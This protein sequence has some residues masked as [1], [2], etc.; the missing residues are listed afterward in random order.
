MIE[1]KKHY[2]IGG[3][4]GAALDLKLGQGV[5]V[6]PDEGIFSRSPAAAFQMRLRSIVMRPVLAGVLSIALVMTLLFG[7]LPAI[8]AALK[9]IGYEQVLAGIW[10]T[11]IQEFV[12]CFVYVSLVAA[13]VVYEVNLRIPSGRMV[14]HQLCSRDRIIGKLFRQHE[15]EKKAQGVRA[16]TLKDLTIESEKVSERLIEQALVFLVAV[17]IV[18]VLLCYGGHI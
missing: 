17:M 3:A 16:Q 8:L 12:A 2:S 14:L 11:T 4:S 15:T 9:A 18:T 7:V 13:A 10:V 6:M 5:A 1:A